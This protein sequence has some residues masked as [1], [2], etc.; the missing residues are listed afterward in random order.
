ME[1]TTMKCKV[2][3]LKIYLYDYDEETSLPENQIEEIVDNIMSEGMAGDYCINDYEIVE[4]EITI[5][6]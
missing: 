1:K 6:C 3:N 4:E 2:L 5:R